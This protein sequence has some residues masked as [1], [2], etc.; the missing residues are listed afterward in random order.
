MSGEELALHDKLTVCVGA[1]VPVPVRVSVAVDDWALL[2][3]VSAPLAA[4]STSGLKVTVNG[5][6]CPAGIVIGSA[7]PPTLN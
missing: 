3:N 6:L 5:A 4:P 7:K 1:G 2:V